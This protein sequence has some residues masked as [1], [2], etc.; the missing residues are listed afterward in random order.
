M[1]DH[2]S[3]LTEEEIKQI[4]Q[5]AIAMA[6]HLHGLKSQNQQL[7]A[8]VMLLGGVVRA[9]SSDIASARKKLSSFGEALASQLDHMFAAKKRQ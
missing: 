1:A 6:Q 9:Q 2:W 7:M 3:D 5:A 8:I 4:E